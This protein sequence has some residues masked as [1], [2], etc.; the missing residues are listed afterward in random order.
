[1]GLI[2]GAL[3]LYAAYG[4]AMIV[5]HPKFIYPFDPQPFEAEGFETH[6]FAGADGEFLTAYVHDAGPG[7]PVVLY[8]MG[9]V[10][11]LQYFTPMLDHHQVAGRSVVALG[12]RGGGGVPGQPSE[13]LLKSDALALF[14]AYPG[15]LDSPGPVVV[16]GY[17]LGTGL[18]LHVAARR[19]VDGVILSAPYARLC[20]LMAKAAWLPACVMPGVQKWNSARDAAGVKA[21]VLALHGTADALVPVSEGRRLVAA[22]PSALQVTA[23]EIDGA[24]HS[25]LIGFPGY[26]AEIDRFIEGL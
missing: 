18:A 20:R 15:W 5:M 23:V 19:K 3:A 25:D 17:S 26:L 12:F 11:A 1:M 6:R 14:E 9:N 22:L 2:A 13:T 21:P 4:V 16:Q 7:A 8:L 10:G 24:G